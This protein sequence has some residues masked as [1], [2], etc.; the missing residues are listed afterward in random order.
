MNRQLPVRHVADVTVQLEAPLSIGSGRSEGHEDVVL[1]RDANGL[2]V[3][4]GSSLAGVLRAAVARALGDDTSKELFGFVDGERGAASRVMLSFAHVHDSGN[5]VVEGL[6]PRARLESDEVLAPLLAD[7]PAARPHVKLGHRG[8]AADSALFNRSHV[9]PGH[10]FSFRLQLHGETRNDAAWSALFAMLGEP[11]FRLGG[12]SRR[13]YGQVSVQTLCARCFDLREPSDLEDYLK[14]GSRLGNARASELLPTSTPAAEATPTHGWLHM[15]LHL[16]P[17][18]PW[19][20]GGGQALHGADVD[21]APWREQ[22]LCWSNDKPKWMDC[23]V[24]PGSSIRGALAHRTAFH[25]QRITGQFIED[26]GK[27]ADDWDPRDQFPALRALLGHVAD[28]SRKRRQGDSPDETQ[29][30]SN[31]NIVDASRS[32]WMVDD[33]RIP[34]EN[35]KS[36]NVWNLTHNSIDRFTGGVRD[37]M[38]YGEQVIVGLPID[39]ALAIDTSRPIAAEVRQALRAA[40]EDLAEG[41]LALGASVAHGHGV[42]RANIDSGEPLM[43]WLDRA[44]EEEPA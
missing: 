16:E 41:R 4:P 24:V 31:G 28:D 9:P 5:R 21:A 33:A 18:T 22:S 36:K 15:K 32:N 27:V 40:L 8:A 3:I 13:G 25:Y 2:P 19:R 6:H 34:V 29:D 42:F 17:V 37:G 43:Q 38:L 44:P 1:A 26:T 39:T 20:I 14:L 30:A 35:V 7:Q 23:V 10:R 12:A 11:G